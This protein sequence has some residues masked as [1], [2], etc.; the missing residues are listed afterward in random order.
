M[1]IDIKR[2][3]LASTLVLH[4]FQK[5]SI[6]LKGWFNYI[7]RWFQK[8][9]VIPIK[10]DITG[11]NCVKGRSTIKFENG[12]KRLEQ[13]NF[14]EITGIWIAAL[15]PKVKIEMFD[16]IFAAHLDCTSPRD[17]LVLCWDD[18]IIRF[19][20]GYLE[21]LAKD[22]YTY[23]Q[24]AYGYGYQ[25]EF[26]QG[27]TFYPFGVL[28]G[29]DAFSEEAKQIT[30]WSIEYGRSDGNYRIGMFRDIYPI[31]FLSKPHLDQKIGNQTLQCW[32]ESSPQHG[33]L[34]TL[35]NN[36]LWSWWI[37]E[38]N[39]ATVREELKPMGLLI[40]V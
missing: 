11:K 37:P 34:H 7:E 39:I 22:L 9:G 27:P 28:S 19:E 3:P 16:F 8:G 6:D 31:N 26:R 24:P 32:I 23:L 12:K 14:Q 40:C 29:I 4:G 18:Q 25:R 21:T 36:K 35:I 38:D 5:N 1:V 2:G 33:E 13:N 15:P 20:R 17:T 30:Q 10:M